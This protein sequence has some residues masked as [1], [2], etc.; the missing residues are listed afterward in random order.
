MVYNF[1][2]TPLQVAELGK[3]DEIIALIK[4]HKPFSQ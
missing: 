4:N 2:K 3:N 1:K